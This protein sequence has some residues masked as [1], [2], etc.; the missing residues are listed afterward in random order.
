MIILKSRTEIDTMRT[1]GRIVYAVLAD[2][3]SHVRPGISTFELDRIAEEFIRARGGIPSFMPTSRSAS[4]I[5]F[6]S[7]RLANA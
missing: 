6:A 1:A 4:G 2:L 7:S 5:R 3:V